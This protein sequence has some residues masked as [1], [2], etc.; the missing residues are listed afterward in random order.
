V[1]PRVAAQSAVV[2][3]PNV[4]VVVGAVVVEAWALSK[5]C[6]NASRASPAPSAAVAIER[7]LA[8]APEKLSSIGDFC[9]HVETL[10]QLFG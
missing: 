2:A 3:G 5:C 6:R 7:C 1:T 4:V 10:L 8:G 9:G